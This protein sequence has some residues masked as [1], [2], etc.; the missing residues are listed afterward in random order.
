LKSAVHDLV[1]CLLNFKDSP[2]EQVNDALRLLAERFASV[3]Q[4]GPHAYAAS[5]DTSREVPPPHT[6][7]RRPP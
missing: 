6:R 7:V 5:A 3:E 1:Y 4:D 2:D